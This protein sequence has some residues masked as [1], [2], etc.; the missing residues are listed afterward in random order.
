M[1]LTRV[2]S[3][4]SNH[5]TLTG[6][7]Y[8]QLLAPV[9]ENLLENLPLNYYRRIHFQHDGASPHNFHDSATMLGRLFDN[10]WIGTNAHI[11]WPPR[12]PD[13]TP[14]D[15]FLWGYVKDK[16]YKQQYQSVVELENK[17]RDIINNIPARSIL[18]V[19]G[20]VIRR[21][22]KCIDQ[23]GHTFEHLLR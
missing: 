23:Q 4:W 10:R 14:L 19:T 1:W 7:R 22:Q 2:S 5:G 21:A 6:A 15:F 20:S 3:Y 17:I 13:L 8:V 9:L 18:K 16:A 11:P 12:S